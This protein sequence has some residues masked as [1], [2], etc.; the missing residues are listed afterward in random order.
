MSSEHFEFQK[1]NI[2]DIKKDTKFRY[3]NDR[4]NIDFK[5]FIIGIYFFLR[6]ANREYF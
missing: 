4:T 3:C 1:V 2:H 6:I 5:H